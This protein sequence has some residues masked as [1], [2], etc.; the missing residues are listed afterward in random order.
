MEI[1]IPIYAYYNVISRLVNMQIILHLLVHH[2][3]L[4]EHLESIILFHQF[5]K[6]AVLLI[7]LPSIQIE[8]ACKIVEL[9]IL[10][11]QLQANALI[12]LLI[13]HLDIME[14]HRLIYVYFLY[15]VKPFQVYIT[16]QMTPQRCVFQSVQL[17]T[18][19]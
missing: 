3:A 18:M 5:A 15:T 13:A 19:A 14:I 1:A 4:L 11:I 17:Q 12:V 16:M 2:F 10:A 6:K 7:L 8:F 9:V